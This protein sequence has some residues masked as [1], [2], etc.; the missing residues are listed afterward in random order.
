MADMLAAMEVVG[1]GRAQ[2]GDWFVMPR[3][4]KCAAGFRLRYDCRQAGFEVLNR[5]LFHGLYY[6]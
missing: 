1:V 4:E 5:D 6:I 2:L 3:D